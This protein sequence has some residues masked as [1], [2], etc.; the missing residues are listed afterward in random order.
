MRK[1]ALQIH[2]W[3]G[4]IIGL[5]LGAQGISGAILAW[6][7]PLDRVVNRQLYVMEP[8]AARLSYAELAAPAPAPPPRA[9]PAPRPAAGAAPGRTSRSGTRTPARLGCRRCTGDDGVYR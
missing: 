1:F 3:T 9:A 7:T 4:L 8:G 2:L 5:L 6:R